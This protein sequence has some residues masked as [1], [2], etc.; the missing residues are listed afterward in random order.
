MA[1]INH[2]SSSWSPRLSVYVH[3]DSLSGILGLP[4]SSVALSLL[5]LSSTVVLRIELEDTHFKTPNWG[6][7]TERALSLD[8]LSPDNSPLSSAL[9]LLELTGNPG[10]RG[11]TFATR[12]SCSRIEERK[13]GGF[14]SLAAP[15]STV[16]RGDVRCAC[17]ES[18]RCMWVMAITIPAELQHYDN[19][20]SAR[21]R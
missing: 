6:G 19:G 17:S 14:Q 9:Q 10:N 12:A 18:S 16:Q 5:W 21:A 8:V 11:L 7:I 3:R 13:E 2:K 20:T 15:N 1:L 4:D